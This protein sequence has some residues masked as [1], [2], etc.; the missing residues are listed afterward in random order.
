MQ[1][2]WVDAEFLAS[3]K[4]GTPDPRQEHPPCGQRL[5]LAWDFPRSL[6]DEK[7]TLVATVR[8]WDNTQEVLFHPVERRRSYTAYYFPNPEPSGDRKILTY[9]VQ[10]VS[11]N[12]TVIETWKHHFWTELIEISSSAAQRSNPSVS[13]QPRQGSVIDK[14]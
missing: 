4:I 9:Q 1:Q 3:S 12:G 7:L 2:E 10:V 5:L 8:F 13:S 14:P 11:S 6:F